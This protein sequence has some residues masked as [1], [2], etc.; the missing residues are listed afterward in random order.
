[1][2]AAREEAE[3]I[4]RGWVARLGGEREVWGACVLIA[5][6]IA[7]AVVGDVVAG[8]ILYGTNERMH[9]WAESPDREVLDPMGDSWFSDEPDGFR[10]CEEHRDRAIAQEIANEVEIGPGEGQGT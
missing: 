7:D 8:R 2:S 4:W 9:W 5:L 1:M 6:E 10:R 3:R